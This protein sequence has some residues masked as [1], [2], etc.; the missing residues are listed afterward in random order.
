MAEDREDEV[1]GIKPFVFQRV[2]YSERKALAEPLFSVGT[3]PFGAIS[4]KKTASADSS[5]WR[6]RRSGFEQFRDVKRQDPEALNA[7]IDDQLLSP[8]P[9]D[10]KL[11]SLIQWLDPDLP[12]LY[13]GQSLDTGNLAALAERVAVEN[14]PDPR[15]ARLVGNCAPTIS[16]PGWPGCVAA[17]VSSR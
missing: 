2:Q 8:L 10:V 1:N 4:T 7:M 12:P 6:A 11:L 17:A 14:D 9:P 13:R 5:A 15:F 16:C 3:R